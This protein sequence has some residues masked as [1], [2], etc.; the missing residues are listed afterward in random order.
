MH[1][2]L[3]ISAIKPSTRQRTIWPWIGDHPLASSAATRHYV[4]QFFEEAFRVLTGAK[5]HTTDG[6]AD[7]CPDFSLGDEY[8]EVKSLSG[9]SFYLFEHRLQNDR[10]LV[11]ADFR[12][13]LT[14]VIWLHNAPAQTY[15][16][17]HALRHGLATHVGDVLVIPFERIWKLT[18]K[19]PRTQLPYR[20]AKDFVDAYRIPRK[21]LMRIS[22]GLGV[23]QRAR[24][25]T[26]FDA[27]VGWVTLRGPDVG[28]LFPVTEPMRERANELL[29]DLSQHQLD[30]QLIPAPRQLHNGHMIR[31]VMDQAP[32]WY[33]HLCTAYP[34]KR[35]GP[36]R[37]HTRAPD[38][39]IRRRFVLGAL[40][41]LARG[42][43]TYEYDWRLRPYIED[44]SVIQ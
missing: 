37:F 3:R 23:T 6:C 24:V 15:R 1:T 43:C 4:G 9:P 34:A 35:T 2:P 22:R 8:Y 26:V 19:L 25:G 13:R 11:D 27:E 36:R 30:V 40:G 7:V 42:V 41:R 21:A 28:R 39:D 10:R 12:H 31:C 17:V 14:Y 20:Q 33:R 44:N 38:T 29:A 18:R 5:Q 16:S 32:L